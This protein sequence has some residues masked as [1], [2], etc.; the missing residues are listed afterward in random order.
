MERTG[1]AVPYS[2]PVHVLCIVVVLVLDLVAY[3]L[4]DTR[5]YGSSGSGVGTSLIPSD[6]P[7]AHEQSQILKY[8][9]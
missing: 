5:R 2:I 3:S 4:I 1:T 6:F 9:S 8:C 7:D